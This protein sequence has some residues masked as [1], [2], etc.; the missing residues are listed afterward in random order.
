M[1]N[2]RFLIDIFLLH[3]LFVFTTCQFQPDQPIKANSEL[4]STNTSNREFLAVFKARNNHTVSFE[5]LEEMV[6]G[7]INPEQSGSRSI[8]PVE[9]TTIVKA[10]KLSI[11]GE[12]RFSTNTQGR[13]AA[14]VKEESVEVYSF[15]TQ[16]P[17]NEKTGYVLA[18]NDVR[19]GNFLAIVE[20]GSLDSEEL[21]WFHDIVYEGISSFIDHVIDEY[22][23]ISE[24]EVGQ[25]VERSVARTI[26]YQTTTGNVGPYYVYG[27]SSSSVGGYYNH[28]TANYPTVSY[29]Q[30]SYYWSSGA[31]AALSTE[32]NQFFPYNY[33]VNNINNGTY[34]YQYAAGCVPVAMGQIMAYHRKPTSTSYYT[35]NWNNMVSSPT[36]SSIS[37]TGAMDIANLMH[38]IGIRV[39]ATYSPGST[40]ANSLTYTKP[41]FQAMGYTVPS[42]FLS[43]TSANFPTL[44]ASIVANRPV[45]IRG[46]A[47]GGHAWV[48]DAVRVMGYFEELYDATG[49]PLIGI[50]GPFTGP[51]RESQYSDWVHCNLGWGGSNN[52]W[53]ASGIFDCRDGYQAH[54]RS[55]IPYYYNTGLQFLPNIH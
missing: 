25:A 36:K 29:I 39:H 18:S 2:T 31:Y 7:F 35:Y 46:K 50:S 27:V 54:A 53:Y 1:K 38:E 14:D 24:E 51:G 11:I 15:I 43:Y 40:E 16:K 12:K 44:R 42:N 5:V 32:W 55:S 33:V 6:T 4:E 26:E 34:S 48:I 21:A 17:G 41:V 47:T 37:D 30:V 22:D 49:N 8:A 9:K 10:D 23:S 13:S 28:M 19:V 45:Y 3:F 52:A 20:E